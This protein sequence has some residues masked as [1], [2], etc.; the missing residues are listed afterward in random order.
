MKRLFLLA[1]ALALTGCA[2]P[3]LSQQAE[4]QIKTVGIVTLVP[5]KANFTKIGLT[6]FNNEYAQIEMGEQ[7]NATIQGT[8][9][10]QLAVVRPGWKVKPVSYP[11]TEWIQRMNASGF[12]VSSP[13][14]RLAKDL[15][16]LARVNQ[17]DA[18]VVV[19]KYRPENV[20][21][22]GV[23]ILLRTLSLSSVGDAYVTSYLYANIVNSKGEV[24]AA[25]WGSSPLPP[26]VIDPKAYGIQYKLADN[27]DPALQDRLRKDIVDQVAKVTADLVKRLGL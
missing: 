19:N 14:E 2:A 15:T 24:Q 6:V 23:G 21:G 27:N 1:V 9:T 18:I 11:R 10:K 20:H 12:F 22:D 3:R 26:K 13:Q 5:E 4:Q 8:L 7:I 17:L 25:S 16:E